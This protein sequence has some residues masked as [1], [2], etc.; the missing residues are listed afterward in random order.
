MIVCEQADEA[1]ILGVIAQRAGLQIAQQTDLDAA[2]RV[3][4]QRPGELI[5]LAQRAQ[6]PQDAVRQVRQVADVPLLVVAP[7]ANEDMLVAAYEAG[8]D[9]VIT[10]PYSA[11]LLIT[12]I[13][14]LLRRSQGTSI[15]DLPTLVYGR[16]ALEPETRMV[17]VPGRDPQRLTQL[18]FRLCH[19]LISARGRTLETNTIVERVW[20]YSGSGNSELVRGLVRRLRTKIESAP[21]KP[22][23]I[24]TVPGV[25]Y[26]L[27]E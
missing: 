27:G 13:R 5:I 12:Q 21:H 18:E 26:R 7:N 15:F 10:R 23:Y 25:G 11:R 3:W 22:E 1:D 16:L 4:P 19:A 2:I 6:S 24:I 8:A 9:L 17:R 20:G 14:A